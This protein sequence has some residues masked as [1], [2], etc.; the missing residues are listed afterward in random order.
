MKT[1][2]VLALCLAA[3]E[4][5]TSS[6]RAAPR[7]AKRVVVNEDFG[8]MSGT[9]VGFDD[10][11]GESPE[12]LSEINL[13][14]Y[15]GDKGLR[16]KLTKTDAELEAEGGEAVR[17]KM[18][19]GPF[20]LFSPTWSAGP[21]EALGFTATSNNAARRQE[22]AKA[23]A[24]TLALKEKYADVQKQWLSKY[25]YKRFVG[26]WF[27]ADQLSSDDET[28]TGGFNMKKGG[29]YPDGTYKKPNK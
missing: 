27:Y 1:V 8:L 4:A 24:K 20:Q 7:A 3:A 23:I 21:M 2:A 14:N 17:P 6:V 10:E 13:R 29:Y 28:S 22:K 25:G 26:D 12:V 19:L 9:P 5:F 16:F 11:H 15:L 18:K